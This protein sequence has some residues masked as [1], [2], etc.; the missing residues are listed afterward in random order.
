MLV[1]LVLLVLLGAEQTLQLLGQAVHAICAPE[2][3]WPL[4]QSVQVPLTNP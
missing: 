1:L 3:Y 2:E 4:G